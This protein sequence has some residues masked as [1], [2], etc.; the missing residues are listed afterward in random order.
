MRRSDLRELSQPDTYIFALIALMSVG[1]MFFA[2]KAGAPLR[3]S[4]ERQY[5]AIATSI[6]NGTG[7]SF[8]G[9]PT[10]Y[11]PPVWPT[12]IAVF[13]WFGLPLSLLSIVPASAMIGAAFI[14]AYLGRRMARSGW[15]AIAGIGVIAYPLNIYTAVKLYPQ[16]IATL[17]LVLLGLLAY[18]IS[19]DPADTGVRGVVRPA[20]F[21]LVASL[22]ALSVPILAFTSITVLIWAI[23]TA[24]GSRLRLG[25]WSVAAFLFPIGTWTIRNIIVFGKAIPLSSS[26]GQ[27]LL[28]GNN[29]TATGSSGVAVNIDAT[30]DSVSSM[31]EVDRD[32]ALKDAAVAW[33]ADHPGDAIG[34]YIAKI[35]NYFAPYNQPV[36]L[37]EGGNGQRL[38]AYGSYG[39]MIILAILRMALHRYRPISS[40][41]RLFV[42]LFVANSLVMAVFFTRTR[43][44]QPLDNLLIIEG[45]VALAVLFS[46]LVASRG[47]VGRNAERPRGNART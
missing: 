30:L 17:L 24:Y 23:W 4:D 45:A 9:L 41:E 3:Y 29:A 43:F 8:D 20:A 26:G 19:I 31:G 15:G 21:G 38:I 32:N 12:V 1:L 11:R 34:L 14:S 39:V 10:A 25:L 22:L 33:I 5:V 46:A 42:G 6:R 28:I 27:N 47:N 7:F 13:L 18:L 2:Y 37:S 16:A 44:R 40:I 35:V 36:T